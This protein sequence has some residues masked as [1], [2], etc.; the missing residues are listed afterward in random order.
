MRSL[1]YTPP[2]PRSALSGILTILQVVSACFMAWKVLSLWADTPYPAMVVITESMEPAFQRGDLIFIS[3]DRQQ[4]VGIG[5]LPVCWFPER[6]FP[7]VHRVIQVIHQ[8]HKNPDLRYIL[9]GDMLSVL[10]ADTE[11]CRQLIV[12]KGDNNII[13]DRVMY[14][15]DQSYVYRHQIIG[16]VR[17]YMPFIGWTA[18]ILQD[19]MCLRQI[20]LGLSQAAALAR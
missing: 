4:K 14:P 7:M 17:G 6:P 3:N 16:F 5:D 20:I 13:D 12:T 19:P 9:S 10:Y 15:N 8:E 11:I 1:R 18:I 2:A